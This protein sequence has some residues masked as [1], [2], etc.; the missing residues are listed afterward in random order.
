MKY[1]QAGWRG[2]KKLVVLLMGLLLLAL[3]TAAAAAPKEMRLRLTEPGAGAQWT[4]GSTVNVK[5]STR[6]ELGQTV[7]ISL[8]RAGLVNA[9]TVLA[10]AAPIGQNRNGAFKWTIPQDLPVG[11]NYTLTVTAENGIGETSGDFAL[12]AGK[13]PAPKLALEAPAKGEERWQIGTKVRI[14]WN[15]S[16]DP[17]QLVRLALIKKED[18]SATPIVESTPVGVD[19]K[20]QYEWTV[21]ELK[22]DGDYYL[23][24]VS[25]SNP[26]YQDMGKTAL[27]IGK[28]R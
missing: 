22:P 10:E 15:W 28:A 13:G 19:G 27:V 18:S 2:K 11:D 25:T 24:I 5:W 14:R 6:G 26:F 12:V 21:P 23:S 8:Q 1:R 3:M 7:S 4:I 20:G 9:R 17:G 16:G